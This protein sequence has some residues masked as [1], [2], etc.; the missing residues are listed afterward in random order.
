M[1][2]CQPQDCR[3][4]AS[5]NENERKIDSLLCGLLPT[6]S[7]NSRRPASPTAPNAIRSLRAD[8]SSEPA[9]A[10]AASP[11]PLPT[12]PPMEGSHSEAPVPVTLHRHPAE[13]GGLESRPPRSRRGS[14]SLADLL[15]FHS[16]LPSAAPIPSSIFPPALCV[17]TQSRPTLWPCPD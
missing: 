17:I 15:L 5:E 16:L 10:G 1:N 11:A 4:A 9:A 2:E 14:P 12:D 7:K 13:H 8:R 6:K 3:S